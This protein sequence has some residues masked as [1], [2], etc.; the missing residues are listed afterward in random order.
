[1]CIYIYI[2]YRHVFVC[3]YIYI[4]ILYRERERERERGREREIQIYKLGRRVPLARPSG[5]LPKATIMIITINT[6]YIITIT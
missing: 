1:M 4:Y 3:I 6:N 5:Y 2:Y